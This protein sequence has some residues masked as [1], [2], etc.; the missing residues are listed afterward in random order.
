MIDQLEATAHDG[1]RMLLSPFA[2]GDVGRVFEICQDP[3]I[4]KWTTVPSPYLMSHAEQ[5]VN[6]YAPVAWRQVA[7][8]AFSIEDDGPE[9]TWGIRL[10]TD[11]LVGAIGLKPGGR[12]RMEI[13]WWLGPSWRGRGI[14]RAAAETV[15]GM[16]FDTLGA[17][18]ISWHAV[19][20]NHPSAFV[21]QRVG[22]AYQGVI[23][24]DRGIHK[25]EPNWSAVIRQ[26]D[27]I[28]PRDWPK[29]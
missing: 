16:G 19:V 11:G 15:V 12:R 9:L 10:V 4:Q 2:A 25:D 7:A 21:A 13:G 22:F 20:G 27:P 18:E 8:G 29:L 24:V 3:E 14:M 17:A 6:E 28:A 1:T 26:G 23:N 5:Y